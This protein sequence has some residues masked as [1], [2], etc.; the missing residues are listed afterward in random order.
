MPPRFLPFV[1]PA[2]A[3][4]FS[5]AASQADE[6]RRELERTPQEWEDEFPAKV[7]GY[8]SASGACYWTRQTYGADGRR[9]DDPLDITGTPTRSP[10]YP[11]GNGLMPPVEGGDG[12][13]SDSGFPVEVWMRRRLVISSG[14]AAGT[15][16]Y[17]FDWFCGCGTGGS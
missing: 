3:R 9:M 11:V 13:G 6:T 2:E 4:R 17:E 10:A 16:A 1:P 12:S 8:D 5:E 7:T 15:V 14:D